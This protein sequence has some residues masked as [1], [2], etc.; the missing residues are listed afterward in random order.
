MQPEQ[1]RLHCYYGKN[2]RQTD[3][4]A[5]LIKFCDAVVSPFYSKSAEAITL[6]E[7]LGDSNAACRFRLEAILREHRGITRLRSAWFC[8][9]ADIEN[10]FEIR[11]NKVK[12]YQN[13]VSI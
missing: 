9:G 7:N 10:C 2:Y 6:A 3:E 4:D 13:G 5:D 11:T 1:P 12:F 8:Y